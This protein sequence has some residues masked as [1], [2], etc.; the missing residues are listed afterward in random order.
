MRT[1]LELQSHRP[2][3]PS[4][5]ASLLLALRLLSLDLFNLSPRIQHV[6]ILNDLR[7][8]VVGVHII[9]QV[10]IRI[11]KPCKALWPCLVG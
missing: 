11:Q 4:P 10:G 7:M 6:H 9:E 5:A 3:A 2:L 1:A 8:R